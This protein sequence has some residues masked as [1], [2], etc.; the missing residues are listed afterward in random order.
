MIPV[1]RPPLVQKF[2]ITSDDVCYLSMPLFHLAGP[3]RRLRVAPLSPEPR[4]SLPTSPASTFV[5][6][7]SC[8]YPWCRQGS[9][10]RA[11]HL[12]KFDDADTP[13]RAVRHGH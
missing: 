1:R 5:D 7:S 12:E 8:C 9:R 3:A 2:G 11:R 10:V 13:L 4:S 6:D